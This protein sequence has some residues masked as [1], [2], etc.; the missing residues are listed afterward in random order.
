VDGY[1]WSNGFKKGRLRNMIKV[2]SFMG[3]WRKAS[4]LFE[5]IAYFALHS[6]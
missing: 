4:A 1:A 5:A 3:S 2:N 6:L